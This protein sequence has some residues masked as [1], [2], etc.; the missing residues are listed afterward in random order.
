LIPKPSSNF[1]LVQC[2]ECGEKMVIFNYTNRDINCK[3]CH[4]PIA[5][6]TGSKAK[7]LGKILNT[8]E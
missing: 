7:I 5:E 4:K 1:I 8:L 3:S 6:K 2:T